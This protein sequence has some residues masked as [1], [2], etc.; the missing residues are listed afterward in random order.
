MVDIAIRELD[1]A[2]IDAVAG[3]PFWFAA[4]ALGFKAGLAGS[5]G[6]GAAAAIGA[7]IGVAAAA[8]AIAAEVG[9]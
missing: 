7:S 4:L 3:G 9:D 8:G 6:T 5:A 1:S 2:E